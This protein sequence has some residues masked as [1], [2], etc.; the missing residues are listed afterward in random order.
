MGTDC[1]EF[2]SAASNLVGGA[3]AEEQ[4]RAS[5]YIAPFLPTPQEVV[6]RMLALP[7]VSQGDLLYD[8]GLGD[9]RI[10][11]TAAR[12]Y[13]PKAVGFDMDPA[14]VPHSA[15]NIQET[16]SAALADIREQH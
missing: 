10:V 6:D 13:E 8:L 16:G 3:Y 14:L 9:G 11:I 12:R 4:D 7:E 5:M 1:M 2:D 15:C